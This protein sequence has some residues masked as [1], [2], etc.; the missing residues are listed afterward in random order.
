MLVTGGT[1]FIGAHSVKALAN[2]G[3]EVRLLVRTPDRID[4]NVKPL[5]VDVDDYVVGDMGDAAA[6]AKAMDG[7]DAVL[8][9][10]AV[11]ALD[12]RRAA[13]ILAANPLGARVVIG[14]AADRGL[15][16]I[17]YVSS[18]SAL[19]TPGVPLLHAELPPAEVGSA[20]GQSK[21]SAEHYVRELQE[22]GAPITI[23][24]PGGVTGPPA[25]TAFGEFADSVVTVLQYGMLPLRDGSLALI[26][27][28][29]LAAVHTAVMAP[30]HGPRRFMCGGHFLTLSDYAQLLRD[31]T[32]R[33]LPVV[34]VP[35][36]AMRAVGRAMDSL[37]RVLP[38][39]TVFTEEAMSILTQWAPS[40]D[41]LLAEE[42]GV[43]LRDPR[44]TID[45]VIRGLHLAGRA[46]ARLV[47][48]VARTPAAREDTP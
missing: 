14:T 18:A 45:A 2:A 23:T 37:T 34:P 21:A 48:S 38:F 27:V 3:H 22:Q 12:R 25:G 26:D 28:R 41:R 44:E 30:H 29:D 7:C 46:S 11:V 4:A 8:H 17:V 9:C 19:F 32:G 6:V 36:P 16:P 40:D 13:E 1:G 35:A 42:L 39:D 5:G 31:I 47:G 33:S 15:D 10:A 43:K 24:Y 20:Y